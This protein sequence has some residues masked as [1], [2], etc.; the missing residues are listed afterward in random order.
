MFPASVHQKMIMSLFVL[1]SQSLPRLILAVKTSAYYTGTAT[2]PHTGHA[3]HD[4]TATPTDLSHAYHDQTATPRRSERSYHDTT[5]HQPSHNCTVQVGEL[6]RKTF[7][8]LPVFFGPF[9]SG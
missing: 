8:N 5:S 3:Y 7:K 2:P 4:Q 6:A 9:V 1:I